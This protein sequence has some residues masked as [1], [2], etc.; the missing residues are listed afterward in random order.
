MRIIINYDKFAPE[1]GD[2]EQLNPME[3]ML[4]IVVE[5]FRQK[6]WLENVETQFLYP[7]NTTIEVK[8][9]STIQN[10]SEIGELA[11]ELQDQLV[12][13]GNVRVYYGTVCIGAMKNPKR[14]ISSFH[15]KIN[16]L[17]QRGDINKA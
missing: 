12:S 14:D 11:N 5:G 17:V 8:I 2:D 9:P 3:P 10:Y 6:G 16:L 15:E 1:K 13:F 7:L 4:S